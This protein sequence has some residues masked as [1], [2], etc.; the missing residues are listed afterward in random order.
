MNRPDVI[1]A[2]VKPW[3]DYAD[4]LEEELSRYRDGYKGGCYACE[5]VGELNVKLEAEN[6]RLLSYCERSKAENTK[7]RALA[8]AVVDDI[9]SMEFANESIKALAA[10]LEKSE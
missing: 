9:G 2:L 6:E 10:L 3:K 5:P 1:I 4:E 8:Q 7:L